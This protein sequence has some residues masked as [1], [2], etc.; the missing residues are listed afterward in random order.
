M[1]KENCEEILEIRDKTSVVII[2]EV[3]KD[4]LKSQFNS[5]GKTSGK[6]SAAHTETVYILQRMDGTNEFEPV[7]SIILLMADGYDDG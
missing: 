3:M 1:E 4:S 6:Y 5:V 2:K 7:P